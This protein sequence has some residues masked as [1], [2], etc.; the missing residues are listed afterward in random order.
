MSPSP[1]AQQV[2]LLRQG[3]EAWNAWR[4][5]NPSVKPSLAGADL[6]DLRLKGADLSD[7]D[8]QGADLFRTELARAN[9]KMATLSGADLSEAQLVDA[10]LYKADLSG[11]FLTRADLTGSYL[12]SADLAG[13]DLGGATLRGADLSEARLVGAKLVATDLTQANLTSADIA[14]ANL[15]HADLSTANL[16]GMRYG[17]FRSMHGH[18]FAIRGLGSTYGNALFVRDAQDQ[19]YLETMKRS[20][21]ATAS[22][23]LRRLKRLLFGLWA[24]IDYGRSLGKPALYAIALAIVFGVVYT[25][26]LRLGWGLMDY[27]QSSE[28]WLSPFYYS[29]VTY[30]TLGFGDITPQTWVG[31]LIV[32]TEVVLGYTT[33]GLLLAILANRVARRA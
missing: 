16:F 20:I 27:S 7:A 1:D 8:L 4:R 6:S 12:A 13:A 21:E 24:R 29:M 15:S 2:E 10:E 25:I 14:E 23:V 3:P 17:S 5:E 30:T 26:D 18:Y 9:L 31:E 28:S 32:V 11:S 19:D 22:P 33:L